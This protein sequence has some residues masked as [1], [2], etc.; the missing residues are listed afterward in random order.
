[1]KG[2]RIAVKA[3]EEP[4]CARCWTHDAQV[5]GSHEHPELCPRCLEAI[6]EE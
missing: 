5:G 3:S 2:V 1:F 6:S 4:K